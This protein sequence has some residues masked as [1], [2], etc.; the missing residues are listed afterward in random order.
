MSKSKSFKQK[1][2]EDLLFELDCDRQSGLLT[3]ESVQTLK[4]A[5]GFGATVG[6]ATKATHT[7]DHDGHRSDADLLQ[8]VCNR[9]SNRQI[10]GQFPDER[11]QW[12]IAYHLLDEGRDQIAG[13][14]E[15]GS[16]NQNYRFTQCRVKS[17]TDKDSSSGFIKI[18]GFYH[19]FTTDRCCTLILKKDPKS[20]YGF[21][22]QSIY[23]GVSYEPGKGKNQSVNMS[24]E[25][26]STKDVAKY[27]KVSNEDCSDIMKQTDEY[28]SASP[29]K[30]AKLLLQSNPS[31]VYEHEDYGV[32]DSKS[33]KY[34]PHEQLNIS[35]GSIKDDPPNGEAFEI[36]KTNY[37]TG[38]ILRCF[39]GENNVKVKRFGKNREK[40]PV[41]QNKGKDVY[42][43]FLNQKQ[44]I[45]K[46]AEIEPDLTRIIR[47]VER[48]YAKEKEKQ[49]ERISE[50]PE[51]MNEDGFRNPS[52]CPVTS[53][54]P[55]NS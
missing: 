54:N 30:K 47:K 48:D 20:V 29:L 25:R 41:L 7:E 5:M 52:R 36:R 31:Q 18:G 45:E 11:T 16:P 37:E 13:F 9:N 1:K 19:R 39:V 49:N 32:F 27:L 2:L 55:Y 4:K 12:T 50:L 42:S 15:F 44:D 3:D 53:S 33:K 35:I 40:L 23:P 43:L 24:N 21:A 8:S 14:A 34:E 17:A 10:D 38:E 6:N 51:F 28:K 26:M 22:V 46:F